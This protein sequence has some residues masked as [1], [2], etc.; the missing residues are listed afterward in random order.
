MTSRNLF[1]K[2]VRQD[3]RKRIWCPVLIFITY[4]LGLEVRLLMETEKFL[5]DGGECIYGG[6][7]CDIVVYV[8]HL[9]F[10]REAWMIAVV[11]CGVA[12]LCGISG[13]AYL[14]SRTQLD[15]YH[16][17][18]VSRTQLFWS[19]Y[20]SGIIQFF[21][22]CL[23]HVLICAGIAANRGAFA[24]ETVPAIMSYITLQLV[25]FVL[26]YGAT[27][28][29][30]VLTGNIIVSILGTFVLFSYSAVVSALIHLL[31]DRFFQTYINYSGW[32][33]VCLSEKLGCFSPLSML[34]KL[35]DR[36]YNTTMEAAQQFYTYDF[37]YMGI[38]FAAA[39]VYSL[40]AY[41]LYLKRASEAAGRSIAFC[42]L[43]PVIKT[44]IVI[45]VSFFAA[46]F[47]SEI[48][49]ETASDKWFL[50]GLFFSFVTFCI[51]MEIIFRLDIRGAF[52]HKK[53]FL[54]NAVCTAL[55]FVVLRYDVTG[56]DTYVPADAQL[57][58]CA[59]SI[60]HL[61][62]LSQHV[63]VSPFGTH[64]L[65]ADDYRM[66]NM[67]M[68]DNQSVMEL[69]RKAAQ[70]QLTYRY[71]DYYE[72]IEEVPEYIETMN[73]QQYYEPISFAYKLRNGEVVNREYYIDIADA[74]TVRLL[75]DIFADSNYKIGATPL[76]NDSWRIAFD[77]VR[78]KSGF[79]RADITLTPEMQAD[80]VG[81]YQKEY[82]D[83]TLDT[84]MH[85]IPVGTID[86]A[87]GNEF[88]RTSYSGEM[89][90]YPQFAETIALLRAYGFDMEEKL[91]ADDVEMI[92]VQ[93]QY[94]HLQY[95]DSSTSSMLSTDEVE[96]TDKEQ[97]QQILDSI[98]S[99]G[100]SWEL[101]SFATYFDRQYFVTVRYGVKEAIFSDYVF[102]KGQIPDFV[103]ISEKNN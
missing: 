91:M 21:F 76:F 57:Q 53:Q 72:G 36:P 33:D 99:D 67:E 71:F 34:L 100:F 25:M 3:F 5:V 95:K 14:H 1:F 78:C 77:T 28:L 43:E 46:I 44:M 89:M 41:V 26:A 4:F 6:V 98:V 50:F 22:P 16:S 103:K 59:I 40:T 58:S 49:Q 93:R 23:I 60:R 96:Y 97:I 66:A 102:I 29:A 75:S 45:P 84:V 12:F 42:A 80:L 13:Y 56:Y 61:M 70:E 27:V 54:F 90:V 15:T 30:V 64:Y 88:G 11:T 47:L 69:A 7:S 65:N 55:L 37:S 9:F 81:T 83:L 94:D 19:R 73:R 8:S 39:A 31:F 17:L 82:M 85:V 101:S 63:R 86:F 92:S 79:K 2:L 74:D 38:M 87:T 24:A 48:S 32:Y 20:V 68:Q 18:P 10:G 62:P 52:M 51:I 35:F